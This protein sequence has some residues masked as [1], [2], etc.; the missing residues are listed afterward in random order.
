MPGVQIP[1]FVLNNECTVA[2]WVLESKYHSCNEAALRQSPISPK[3]PYLRNV[4]QD[5]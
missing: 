5:E 4:N 3:G 2:I 1:R